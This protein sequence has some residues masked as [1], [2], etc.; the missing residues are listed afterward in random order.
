MR[1]IKEAKANPDFTVTIHW[2]EGG[3]DTIDFRPLIEGPALAPVRDLDFF[4]NKLEV[5][6]EGYA[7][8]WPEELHFSAD[9]LWYR[10]HPDDLKTDYPGVAAQ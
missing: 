4:L 9:S 10:V 3:S 2:E 1:F 8:G 7:I 5:V 6:H